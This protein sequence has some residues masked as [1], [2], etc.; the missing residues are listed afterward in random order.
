MST[1]DSI[2][3]NE[4]KLQQEKV[5]NTREKNFLGKR[6]ALHSLRLHGPPSRFRLDMRNNLSSKE[7]HC[8]AA[9]GEGGDTVP[10]GDTRAMGMWH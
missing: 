5:G 7:L 9:Q 6:T 1:A 4:L 8:T 3:N 10:G 2:K